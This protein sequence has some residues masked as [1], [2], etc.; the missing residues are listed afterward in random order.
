MNRD[1]PPG[2]ILPC[3][4]KP[5]DVD[6]IGPFTMSVE[7]VAD[8]ATKLLLRKH[9]DYGP[10]NIAQAPGGPLNGLAVRLHDKVARL[11]HLLAQGKEPNNESLRDTMLDIANYGLIGV[12]VLDSKWPGVDKNE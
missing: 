11:A 3:G 7:N 2:S 5:E 9:A 1:Y 10:K 8:E 6:P 4:V 12:L